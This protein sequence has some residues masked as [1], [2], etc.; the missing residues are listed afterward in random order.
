[1]SEE[2]VPQQPVVAEAPAPALVTVTVTKPLQEAGKKYRPG[3]PLETTEARGRYLVE[4]G[5]VAWPPPPV[6]R[7]P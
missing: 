1:M 7:R 3:D 4:L 2:L 5:L 6:V